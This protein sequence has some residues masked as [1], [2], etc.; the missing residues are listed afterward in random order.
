MLHEP[1]YHDKL[2]KKLQISKI[3]LLNEPKIYEK[4]QRK[5]STKREKKQNDSLLTYETALNLDSQ[6]K[7]Q[8][9]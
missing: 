7:M 8:K 2:L 3:K 4:K 5:L 1:F 9:K 6:A